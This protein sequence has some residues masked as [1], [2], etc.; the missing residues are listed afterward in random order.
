MGW[1]HSSAHTTDALNS[2][3]HAKEIGRQELLEIME[4]IRYKICDEAYTYINNEEEIVHAL[5]QILDSYECR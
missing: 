1:A 3:V 2:I 5:E 4:L